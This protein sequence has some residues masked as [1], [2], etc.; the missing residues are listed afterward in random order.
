MADLSRHVGITA[1]FSVDGTWQSEDPLF[2]V[3]DF[4]RMLSLIIGICRGY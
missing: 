4:G 3:N 1:D 2:F